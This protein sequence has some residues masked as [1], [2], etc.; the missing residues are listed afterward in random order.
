MYNARATDI[1]TVESLS[2]F[3][4]IYDTCL[5]FIIVIHFPVMTCP[6]TSLEQDCNQFFLKHCPQFLVTVHD[7]RILLLFQVAGLREAIEESIC[8]SLKHRTNPIF[9]RARLCFDIFYSPISCT[10]MFKT[11]I[12]KTCAIISHYMACHFY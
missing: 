2:V 1:E 4:T 9:P 8:C 11:Q 5:L 6:C 12:Q 3:L 10:V 7:S